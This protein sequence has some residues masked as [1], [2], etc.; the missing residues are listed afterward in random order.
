MALLPPRVIGPLS[1]CSSGV[2]VQGQLSGSTV[3][4]FADGG[5][6]CEAL[7]A[8]ADQVFTLLAG[9]SL[10]AG[11]RVTAS[12]QL[13]VEISDESYEPVEVQAKPPTIGHVGFRS[14]LWACGRCVWLEGLVPGAAVEVR[15]GGSVL[16]S[17][18][19]YDGNARIGLSPALSPGEVVEAQQE[20]CGDPGPNTIGPPTETLGDDRRRRLGPPT[21]ESPLQACRQGVVVGD[22]VHGARVTLLR[23]AG[24]NVQSCFDASA[25]RF[26]VNPALSEGETV[27]ARQ[28]F[29]D[30]EIVGE[31]AAPVV[32]GPAEPVPPPI[33]LGPLCAGGTTVPLAGLLFAA[34]V[35][36]QVDGSDIGEAEAPTEGQFDFVVPSLPGGSI[37][38]AT[39]ELCGIFSDPSNHVAVDPAP[40]ALPQPVVADP[41]FECAGIVH[42]RQLHPG[43]RVYVR[44]TLLGAPIG[45][46]QVYGA[47][48]D[49]AVAPLLIAG[50][51]IFA[52][53]HGCGSVSSE[54]DRVRVGEHERLRPPRVD[55]PLY[56]CEES[57]RVV[58]VVPGARVDVYVNGV[59]RGSAA[60]GGAE[61][62]VA[63]TG[64]LMVDDA[65]TARQRLCEDVSDQ[66]E[67]V[68]VS[69]F[70]GRWLRVGG[71]DHAQIL[72]VHAA[73]LRTGQIVYFGGDQHTPTLNTS[74]DVDHTRLYDCVTGAVTIVT[75]LSA[76]ADLF[77]AGHAMLEDGRLLVGG[78]TRNWGGGGIHPAGHFIGSRESWIFDPA[79][80]AWAPTT[81]K[82]VTQ[83]AAEVTGGLDIERTGGRWYPTLV[84]LP[85]GKV[86]AIT[87]HP[88]V[89]DSRHN[90]SSLEL[91]DPASDRW[92]IVGATDY[93]NIPEVAGRSYEYPRMHVL[94]DGTVLS[95][96][97]MDDGTCE[98]WHPYSD[99][100]QWEF[101]VGSPPHPTY[102]SNYSLY[103][104]SVL[105]P[106]LHTQEYRPRILICGS[107]T[108]YILDP[109]DAAPAWTATPRQLADHP[110]AGDMNPQRLNLD[111]VLLPTGEVFVSGGV[112]NVNSDATAVRQAE[113][114]DPEDGALGSWRVLP[115]AERPRNYHSVALLMPSGAVWVAGSNFS[116]GTGLDNRE[117]RIE[118]F[119]PWYFCGSRPQITDAPERACAGEDIEIRTPQAAAIERVALLRV[120][121]VTHNFNADQRYVTIPFRPAKTANVLRAS[122]PAN[123]AVLVPGYYL[124]FVLD[125]QRRPSVGRFIQICRPRRRRP[126]DFDIDRWRWLRDLLQERPDR[127]IDIA[128]V[129]QQLRAQRHKPRVNR[130]ERPFIDPHMRRHRTG[131]EHEPGHDHSAPAHHHEDDGNHRPDHGAE[132]YRGEGDD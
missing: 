129:L 81:G 27:A 2:R 124:L 122:L 82:L 96:S 63:I 3:R 125:D 104:T 11:A 21:V 99:P 37:V 31:D 102:R 98:R 64:S 118:V 71:D 35:R 25:L 107:H 29:P 66:G 131:D 44:S 10:P 80:H 119:E 33:A 127:R 42:V 1:E 123:G 6:V 93:A 103:V 67:A 86:L 57:V 74:G 12:Q 121:S 83:R 101:V 108:P 62:E 128:D 75:G 4:V 117:L 14:H 5:L 79:D 54:S 24:P 60:S 30:C 92:E 36:I 58:D 40:G 17:G 45:E 38:T 85:N 87:G 110:D 61:I 115:A 105:L 84:T 70:L 49:V 9:A 59:F 132:H 41:L 8:A 126:F 52:V 68:R 120:G 56:S 109:L 16:G 90:N 97:T 91:F 116:A 53:Q 77:C 18:T 34:R 88:E 39:Q 46:A 19:S 47:E 94:R 65:V 55:D 48:A 43:A 23:S 111:A 106:L 112:K 78:G 72:A 15:A 95:A 7:A 22:V 114:Y 13:G 51:E 32:V 28:E 89:D 73:L 26:G 130:V 100:E 76:A 50:D 20:A 69:E 113:L